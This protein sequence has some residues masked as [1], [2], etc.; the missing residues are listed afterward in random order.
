MHRSVLVETGGYDGDVLFENLGLLRTVESVGGWVDHAPGLAVDRR[1]P[2]VRHFMGQRVRQAYDDLAEPA[3]LARELAILPVL[4]LASRRPALL[5]LVAAAVV[6]LAELGRRRAGLED[7]P[8]DAPLWAPL[9][10]LERGVFVWVALTLR[11]TGGMPY[12][13][14]RIV[15][16]ASSRRDL[17]AKEGR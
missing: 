10:V 5:A 2:T 9:W 1:P 4:A 7:V 11:L 16:A 3:R 17:A 15:R 8:R 12:A 13:G 6:G 14:T